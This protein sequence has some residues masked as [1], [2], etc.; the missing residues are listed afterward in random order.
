MTIENATEAELTLASML[1]PTTLA[2]FFDDYWERKPLKVIGASRDRFRQLLSLHDFDRLISAGIVD[3]RDGRIVKSGATDAS[4]PLFL[5]GR[6][7]IAVV[8]SAYADGH[9]IVVNNV[10]H[11]HAETARVC[12]DIERTLGQ[13]VGANAYLTP[14]SA[15]GLNAHFDNHDVY[16]LQCEGSKEWRLY[17]PAIDLPLPDQHFDVRPEH[18]GRVIAEHWLEPGDL[19]YLPR[20]FVHGAAATHER[21]LHL[22]LGV[23]SYRLYDVLAK[24]L[25]R[26]ASEDVAFRRSTPP[27]FEQE[28]EWRESLQ[29]SLQELAVKFAN[30]A[31]FGAAMTDTRSDLIFRMHALPDAGLDALER[32][33]SLG[34]GTRV[35]RRAGATCC[36]IEEG[37]VA[38][39]QFPGNAMSAPVDASE[40]LHFIART[41]AFTV[42]DL[43]ASLT[44]GGKVVIARRLVAMGL[45]VEESGT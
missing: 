25:W 24:A 15:Q 17:E 7:N 43:P 10:H 28:S 40:A 18:I 31:D 32:L 12:R 13:P 3:E 29:Q 44:D 34:L 8:H 38:V 4:L 26:V 39:I 23:S 27:G 45:L 33:G 14:A 42:R 9:T 5:G 19:L 11:R 6:A 20:G 41:E 22:T 36:V 1:A 30:D 35:R 16:V 21:S 37:D 2:E